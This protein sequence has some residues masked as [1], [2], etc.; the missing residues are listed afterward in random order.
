MSTSAQVLVLLNERR[1]SAGLI[2]LR[3]DLVLASL[4]RIH[5]RDMRS[6][7][8]FAHDDPQGQTFFERLAYLHRRAIGEIQAYGTG[9]YGSPAG[10]MSLW[11]SSPEHKRIILTPEFRRV[12]CSVIAGPFL[13]QSGVSLA[14]CDFSS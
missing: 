10:L 13:G 14:V 4:A 3:R 11:L 5:I 7:G 6:K 1:H 2:G 9:G 8:F 12:G